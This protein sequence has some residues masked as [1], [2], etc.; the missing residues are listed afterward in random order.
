[1]NILTKFLHKTENFL[2]RKHWAGVAKYFFELSYMARREGLLALADSVSEKERCVL[3]KSGNRVFSKI[4]SRIFYEGLRLVLDGTDYESIRKILQD[5][6]ENAEVGRGG[7]IALRIGIEG[8]ICAQ[9]GDN[10]FYIKKKLGSLV[11]LRSFDLI[12]TICV[13][14]KEGE[15]RHSLAFSEGAGE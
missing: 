11:D 5:M 10:P 12:D 15:K 3:D 13:L 7:R 4:E 2:V 14:D 1:M 9:V 8:I 6:A